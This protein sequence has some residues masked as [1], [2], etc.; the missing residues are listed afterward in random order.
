MNWSDHRNSPHRETKALTG[1]QLSSTAAWHYLWASKSRSLLSRY[2]QLYELSW[3]RNASE[4]TRAWCKSATQQSRGRSSKHVT[5]ETKVTLRLRH[6]S[7]K[8]CSSVQFAPKETTV[9]SF[10]TWRPIWTRMSTSITSRNTRQFSLAWES[11]SSSRQKFASTKI[12][13]VVRSQEIRVASVLRSHRTSHQCRIDKTARLAVQ[14]MAVLGP[15]QLVKSTL[16][17]GSRHQRNST[18]GTQARKSHHLQARSH[19][20]HHLVG[21]RTKERMHKAKVS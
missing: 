3:S 21:L 20:S 7:I 1:P 16:L 18:K 13:V 12:E 9:T 11:K 4:I 15:S 2:S 14:I 19:T 8:Q 5:T 17:S 6:Q 10:L